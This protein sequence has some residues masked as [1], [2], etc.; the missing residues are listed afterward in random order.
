MMVLPLMVN[1]FESSIID[2]KSVVFN[3]L[4]PRF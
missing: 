3:G 1:D 4:E 2:F